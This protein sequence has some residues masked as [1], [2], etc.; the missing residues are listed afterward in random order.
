MIVLSFVEAVEDVDVDKLNQLLGELTRSSVPPKITP[1]ALRQCFRNPNFHLCVATERE[2]PPPQNIV[3]MA[4]IFFQRNLSGWLA[5]IHD[6][7]VDEAYRGKH[8]GERLIDMLLQKA[9]ERA[10]THNEKINL[11]LTSNPE[12]VAANGLYKKKGF[13]LIATALGEEG[14]N[15]YEMIVTP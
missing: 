14:T 8:I 6:V 1:V 15:L 3:G 4:T 12:R 9:R 11:F 13:L 7:V 10:R 5:E 2:K